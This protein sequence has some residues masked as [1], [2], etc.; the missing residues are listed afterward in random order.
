[1]TTV[2][3]V[4]R[5]H[6]AAGREADFEAA[7]AAAGLLIRPRAIQGFVDAELA[8]SLAT[9]GEYL[10][11][12]RWASADAYRAWQQVSLTEA[13]PDAL[14]ALLETLVDPQ[15]G[16]AFEVLRTSE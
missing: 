9:P 5:F 2:R 13:P 10:V 4:I 16:E 7:F 1:M 11:V 14:G 15:P 3:S 8:R 6:V 12:A